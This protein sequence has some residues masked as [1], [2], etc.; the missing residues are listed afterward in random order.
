MS[1]IKMKI[2]FLHGKE[3][4][5][6]GKKVS[7][8]VGKGYQVVA[9]DLPKDDWEGSIQHALSCLEVYKPDVII[10]SSRGGAVACELDVTIPKILIAPAYLKFFSSPRPFVD[11]STTVLHCLFDDIVDYADSV[12]LE[13]LYG[14]RLIPCGKNH[15]MSDDNALEN[16]LNEV[17][18]ILGGINESI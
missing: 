9:P 8:L 5:P 2:L 13:E 14:C 6:R 11:E 10:G 1:D 17:K 3:G 4:S 12:R 18:T 16:I 7:F 15:R